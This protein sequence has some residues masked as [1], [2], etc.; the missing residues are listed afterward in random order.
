MALSCGGPGPASPSAAS[1]FG[2]PE[3]GWLPVDPEDA[4]SGATG[5]ACTHI[6]IADPF[7]GTI[8]IDMGSAHRVLLIQPGSR[9]TLIRW[10]T[11]FRLA[12]DP[13]PRVIAPVG[14]G[15]WRNGASI[16]FESISRASAVGTP[17]KPFTV[18]G[19][20]A[21]ECY[22]SKLKVVER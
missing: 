8:Q 9:P 11:G 20:I 1:Q 17:E 3:S 12:A 16:K 13:V 6:G 10:P 19:W 4:H 5:A 18:Y 21:D 2:T 22:T 15:S 14:A 7:T